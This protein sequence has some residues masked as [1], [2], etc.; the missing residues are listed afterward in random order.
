MIKLLFYNIL[1]LLFLIQKT[2]IQ[3]MLNAI[4]EIMSKSLYQM[5]TPKNMQFTHQINHIIHAIGSIGH[6]FPNISVLPKNITP[7]WIAIYNKTLE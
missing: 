3:P 5:D 7:P 4:D 2:I 6:G 1:L